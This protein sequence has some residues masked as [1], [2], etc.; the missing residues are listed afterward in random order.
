MLAS[1]PLLLIS[2]T[3]VELCWLLIFPA[4]FLLRRA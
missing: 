3:L 2:T 1:L 4:Q